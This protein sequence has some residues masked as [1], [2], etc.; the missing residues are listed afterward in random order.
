[1]KAKVCL[2]ALLVGLVVAGGV[3]TSLAV[4]SGAPSIDRWVIAGGGGSAVAGGT[5][6]YGIAGQPVVGSDWSN[7]IQ[8]WHGFLGGGGDLSRPHSIYLPVVV[9]DVSQ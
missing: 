3:G 7:G 9:R 4:A 2:F 8:L 1:M 6:L 5:S